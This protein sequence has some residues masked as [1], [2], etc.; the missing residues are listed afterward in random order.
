VAA[1][2]AAC[3]PGIMSRMMNY[4]ALVL[5]V[6]WGVSLALPVATFG[7]AADETWPGWAV[8]TL[9]WLGL[10][11][12]Q[13][14]W[15]ANAGFIAC[16]ILMIRP[17]APGRLGIALGLATA[18]LAL[19][20]LGWSWVYRNDGPRAVPAPIMGFHAGYYLW[21][22]TTVAAGAMLLAYALTNRPRTA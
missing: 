15:L 1:A 7:P 4:V 19:H 16:L 9:G 17:R 13:F 22:A 3:E 8:L 14:G 5:L 12:G 11:T 6:A 21:V 18:G 20:S 10:L 2:S